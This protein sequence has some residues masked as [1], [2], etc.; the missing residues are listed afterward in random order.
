M[1]I[2]LEIPTALRPFRGQT[3]QPGFRGGN[4]WRGSCDVNIHVCRFAETSLHR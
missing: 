1:A 3:I 2:K 4:G